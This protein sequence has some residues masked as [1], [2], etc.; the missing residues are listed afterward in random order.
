[1]KRG[2]QVH[3]KPRNKL[4][5]L[6]I[7]PKDKVAKNDQC[8]VVY[9]VSCNDCEASYVGE[10]GRSLG[11]RMS[12]HRHENS[13]VQTHA[14]TTGHEIRPDKAKILDKESN[15]YT[16]GVREAIH[17]KVHRS[18]LNRD[19]GRYQLPTVYSSL[20]GQLSPPGDSDL[21]ANNQ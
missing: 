18:S 21:V 17:I 10:T 2:I 3:F 7:A 1:M 19:V 15:W 13:A 6:L 4:R 14:N 20:L 12:E 5:E 9:K 16:R 11:T 8:G